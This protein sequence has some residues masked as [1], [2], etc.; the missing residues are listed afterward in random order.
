MSSFQ[1]P[2][3]LITQIISHLAYE[4]H[5]LHSL[6][7]VDKLCFNVAA[8]VLYRNPFRPCYW[9]RPLSIKQRDV[10]YL[11][12]ASANLLQKLEKYSNK[13]LTWASSEWQPPLGPFTVN[14]LQYYTEID[15]SHWG[16]ISEEK[17]SYVVGNSK[18]EPEFCR[19]IHLLFCKYNARNIKS[20]SLPILDM[21]PYLPLA[22]RLSSLQRVEFIVY[23]DGISRTDNQNILTIQDA[24]RFIKI[25]VDV[26]DDTLTEIK[27]PDLTNLRRRVIGS[28][29]Q[30]SDMIRILKRPQVI[31]VADSY[32]FSQFI[33]G[34]IADHLR[35]FS[36]PHMSYDEG[37]QDWD[38]L[39][40]L[41]RCPKLEKIHFSSTEPNSFRWAVE[42]RDSLIDPDSSSSNQSVI[43]LP[44]LQDVDIMYENCAALPNVQDIIYAF[45]NTIKSIAVNEDRP[46]GVGPEPLCWDWLLPN[47]VKLRIEQ[48][49]FSL[50]DFGSLNFCPSLEKICLVSK[51]EHS[52][53]GR[54]I[55][56]SSGNVTEFGPALRL[57]NL[58]KI[59]L[60]HEV[61]YQFNF[62]SLKYSPLLESLTITESGLCLPI[63]LENSACWAWTWDWNLPHLKR[64]DL[65]GESA[66]LF[67]FRLLESCPPLEYLSLS[68]RKYHRVLSLDEIP[69]TNSSFRSKYVIPEVSDNELIQGPTF[70][71]NGWWELTGETL[72]VLSRRYMSHVTY[73][74]LIGTEGLTLLD[75]IYA[76]HTLPRARFVHSTLYLTNDD[77]E[78]NPMLSRSY[79]RYGK[80]WE[81]RCSVDSVDY[82]IVCIPK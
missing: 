36:G 68:M 55:S 67:Q 12:L 29:E 19:F 33:Q 5:T 13:T 1:I 80:G 35:V 9:S 22:A 8:S 45:R 21:K 44:P 32:D 11:L 37:I 76:T 50:F 63:R 40:L 62:D 7:T 38:S 20:V 71:L 24:I 51:C 31:D 47:L 81:F 65:E 10:L 57:P 30:I 4:K 66:F 64:L 59:R 69:N 58:R 6:L 42:R 75:V 43:K 70:K 72:Y 25:H 15:F 82:L 23:H 14:Y 34:S 28:N 78:N 56:R 54:D 74:D 18:P 79:T 73:I 49:D 77:L 53:R 39:S 60:E 41:Q 61:S 16:V 3:D 48:V 46:T 2:E 52:H 17:F 26:F 27:V